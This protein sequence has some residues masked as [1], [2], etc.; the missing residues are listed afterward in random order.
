[1]PFAT[2]VQH[3]EAVIITFHEGGDDGGDPSDQGEEGKDE[4]G[5]GI[6]CLPEGIAESEADAPE[7][8]LPELGGEPDIILIAIDQVF[9]L[10]AQIG[11]QGRADD[12]EQVLEQGELEEY[13]DQ[14]HHDAPHDK[15]KAEEVALPVV[16][17]SFD[18]DHLA[19]PGNGGIG[20]IPE[21]IHARAEQDSIQHTR[22]NDPFP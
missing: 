4:D 22:D 10:L 2:I 19:E 8:V 1:M 21:E 5:D 9:G 3:G 15:D 20:G 13:Q 18:A 12:Q 6:D 16:Q 11:E 17:P 14:S 7:H